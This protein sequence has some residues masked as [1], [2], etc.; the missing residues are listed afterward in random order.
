V[1]ILCLYLKMN[2]N[3]DPLFFPK[4]AQVWLVVFSN[5]LPLKDVKKGRANETFKFSASKMDVYHCWWYVLRTFGDDKHTDFKIN[6]HSFLEEDT[7]QRAGTCSFAK[8]GEYS[9]VDIEGTVVGKLTVKGT[10]QD[11]EKYAQYESKQ[12]QDYGTEW[13]KEVVAVTPKE[14]NI[15]ELQHFTF[16]S[17]KMPDCT[18]P[19][20]SYASRR[21]AVN[22]STLENVF[23]LACWFMRVKPEQY[24]T[25]PIDTQLEINAEMQSMATRF[26]CY[27][28]DSSKRMDSD[29][30]LDDWTYI[31]D[32]PVPE[33]LE[34]DCEDGAVHA[35]NQS[36]ALQESKGPAAEL[37]RRY[38]TA[39]AIV[40]LSLGES[41]Y[42]YHAVCMKFPRGKLLKKLDVQG[43]LP[44]TELPVI[45]VETTAWTTSNWRFKSPVVTESTFGEVLKQTNSVNAKVPAPSKVGDSLYVHV[46]TLVFPELVASAAIGQVQMVYKGKMGV[47]IDVIMRGTDD[48]EMKLVHIKEYP[49]NLPLPSTRAFQT[50]RISSIPE[51]LPGNVK[52]EFVV[53]LHDW[54]KNK[55]EIVTLASRMGGTSVKYNEITEVYG[56][57]GGVCISVY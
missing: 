11:S 53:R 38:V 26:C 33:M 25:L 23:N 55:T 10:P 34:F 18:M 47:P 50:T 31:E 35:V 36:L 7:V 20:W 46:C 19:T 14:S 56:G 13:L 30:M 48:Y 39:F 16:G 29:H 32:S 5:R 45:L 22:A 41:N 27:A 17:V 49:Q 37:E 24:S 3:L 8:D 52:A 15:T 54:Q 21:F 9:F 12:R 44:D 6:E 1:C 28:K 40:T 2:L 57:I 51:S 43:S 4:D 42:T